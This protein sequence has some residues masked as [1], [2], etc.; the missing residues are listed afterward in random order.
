MNVP[1]TQK[2]SAELR[3]A[4]VPGFLT[5]QAA[6]IVSGTD[7]DTSCAINTGNSKVNELQNILIGRCLGAIHDCSCS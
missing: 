6:F 1:D 7:D 2:E 3:N 4:R 5:F